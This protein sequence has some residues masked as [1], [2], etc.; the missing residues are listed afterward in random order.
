MESTVSPEIVSQIVESIFTTMLNLGVCAEDAPP[1]A[2]G[3]RITSAVFLEGDWNGAVSLECSQQQ[4]CEFAGHFLGSDPPEAVDDDVRDVLGEMANMIGGNVK[5]LIPG[6]IRL[7][8]PSVIDGRD[9]AVHVCGSVAENRLAFRFPGG[10]FWVT[11]RSG[12]PASTPQ[13]GAAGGRLQ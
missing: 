12:N 4:A 7:S 8:M 11:I 1:P 5:S 3:D 2:G 6:Q 9:Y 13:N 10:L